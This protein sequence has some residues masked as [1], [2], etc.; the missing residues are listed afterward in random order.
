MDEKFQIKR[1][2]F[3]CWEKSGID[4]IASLLSNAGVEIISSG[5]TAEFLVKKNIPVTK[6]EEVTG[7]PEIL[8]GRVKTLHP[9]IH[10]GILARRTAAHLSQLQERGIKPID[11]VVVNLYPFLKA[12]EQ[13]DKTPDEMIEY[14]D[15]GGPA[16]IRAAAKNFQDVM[17]LHRP[18]QYREF[19]QRFR[20]EAG[21]ISL[22][23]RRRLAAE[24]FYY[25]SYYDSKIAE[26]L[27]SSS[28]E[29]P[30]RISQFYQIKQTLRYG[31][32]P[33]QKAALY[34]PFDAPVNREEEIVQISGKEMS[35]NNYVDVSAAYALVTELSN[36]P[37]PAALVRQRIWKKPSAGR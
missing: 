3:S 8:D 2:L 23:Y 9:A 29:L 19:M 28:E 37:I 31:E 18:E 14:I 17:V 26:Y 4:E 30:D 32:N 22:Q 36:T 6:V 20:E 10:G 35:F 11:L 24:A 7:F 27:S 1:A 34:S 16:M 13:V 21:G 15:I 12:L 25:T 33:H 5:G